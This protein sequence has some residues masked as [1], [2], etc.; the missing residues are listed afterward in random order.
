V[1]PIARPILSVCDKSKHCEGALKTRE[2]KRRQQVAGVENAGR[3]GV[4][5]RNGTCWTT[6][7]SRRNWRGIQSYSVLDG[8]ETLNGCSLWSIVSRS[9]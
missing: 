9:G 6:N 5:T 1:L 2:W 4:R 3:S 7:A 8:R